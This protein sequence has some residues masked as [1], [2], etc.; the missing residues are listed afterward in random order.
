MWRDHWVDIEVYLLVWVDV[1]FIIEEFGETG[2]DVEQIILLLWTE[3]S[4]AAN[5]SFNVRHVIFGGKDLGGMLS[6]SFKGGSN[7]IAV[8]HSR[9]DMDEG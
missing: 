4:A 1:E 3:M 2:Q 8:E 5:D 6:E 7:D 9:L